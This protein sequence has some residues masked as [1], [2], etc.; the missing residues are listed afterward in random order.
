MSDLTREYEFPISDLMDK[1]KREIEWLDPETDE[2]LIYDWQKIHSDLKT[3]YNRVTD[4]K[5][6]S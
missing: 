5:K 2:D 4:L 3:A 1:V 6:Q